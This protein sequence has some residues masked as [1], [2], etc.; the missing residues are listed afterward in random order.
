MHQTG[1]QRMG[2]VKFFSLTTGGSS[3]G[4]T[5]DSGSVCRGS[6]PL[7]P[8]RGQNTPGLTG[9]FGKVGG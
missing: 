2:V 7:P 1:R 8:A 9:C 4:R 5:A 6:N 3:N